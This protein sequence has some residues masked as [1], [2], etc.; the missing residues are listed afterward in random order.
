MV[1]I[2]VIETLPKPGAQ[3]DSDLTPASLLGPHHSRPTDAKELTHRDIT[4]RHSVCVPLSTQRTEQTLGRMLEIPE[5]F[6]IPRQHVAYTGT[7][8]LGKQSQYHG[9]R[10]SP[11]ER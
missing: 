4:A 3:L 10:M 1:F 8:I 7:T 2:P 5:P 9:R 6:Q 11:L